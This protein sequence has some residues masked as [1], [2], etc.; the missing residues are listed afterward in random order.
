MIDK[1]FKEDLEGIFKNHH[2]AV[3]IDESADAEFLLQTVKNDYILHIV[4]SKIEELHIKYLIEQKQPTQEKFLIYTHIKKDNLKFIREY[5]ETSGCLEIRYLHSY[6]KD[7]VHK[8]LNLNINFPKEE[9]ITAAKVSVGKDNTYW[10]NLCHHGAT[11]IFNM[12]TEILEFIHNP[13]TY[14]SERFDSQVCDIFY[15]KVNELLNQDYVSKP[16]ETLAKEV[17]KSMFDGLAYGS[18][19]T[20]LEKV[21]QTWLDSH[22]FKSSFEHYLRQYI[23]PENIPIWKVNPNHPFRLIDEKWLAEVGNNIGNKSSMPNYIDKIRQ[24]AKSKEALALGISFWSDILVLLEFKQSSINRLSSFSECAEF[25]T[26]HFYKLDTAIRNIYVDFLN[27]K[28]LLEPFQNLYKENLSVFLEKWFKYFLDYKEEQTGTLQR[29][30]DSNSMKTAI[31]VGDG[32]SYGIAE[33]VATQVG[34]HFDLHRGTIIAGLPSETENNMSHIYINSGFV[35]SIHAK[36]EKIL[37][38]NNTDKSIGFIRLDEVNDDTKESQFLICTYKDIDEMG[39]NLQQKALKHFPENIKFFAEKIAQLL[40]NG[41]EKVYLISDHGFVLTGLLSEAD[42]IS[43]SPVGQHYKAERY[44]RTVNRQAGM[45]DYLE[46]QQTYKD[47]NYL[48]FARNVNPFKTP[49]VYGFSHGG[50]S[51]QELITPFFYWELSSDLTPS[52]SVFID[53]KEDLKNITGE[54]FLLR[55][56]ADKGAVD[57]FSMERKVYLVFFSNKTKIKESD[58]FSIK[59]GEVVTREYPFD[60]NKEL[61]VHLLD[62]TTRQ[63]LDQVVI[64][65]NKER[66]LGGLF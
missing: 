65:Q 10:I 4:D 63:K 66:D 50:A 60:G 62:A 6:I 11:A 9:L 25:Y 34:S 14:T 27:N 45:D 30:I 58:V 26:N 33:Q 48:Y 42:K 32:I 36:R 19:N 16:P 8:T 64:Q 43:V 5:C 18:C 2:V 40:S 46:V 1:W 23:L 41:Y 35:E 55:I 15:R 20:I 17:V 29:I 59:R 7:K 51:P 47:L 49:G 13:K 56:R 52:L 38:N 31:I 61:D 53:N 12:E 44:I 28:T 3:F 39:E 21:Y 24:R 54:F 57:L 37:S 22:R